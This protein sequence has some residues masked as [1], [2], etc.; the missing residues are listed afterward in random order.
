[1]EI[2]F[3]MLSEIALDKSGGNSETLR[4]SRFHRYY[5]YSVLSF[6]SRGGLQAP[7]RQVAVDLGNLRLKR[8]K[9]EQFCIFRIANRQS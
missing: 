7:L 2:S 1:M 8:N 9:W 6:Q 4:Q 3:P 5:R